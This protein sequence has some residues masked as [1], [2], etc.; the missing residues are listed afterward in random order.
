MYT[1]PSTAAHLPCLPGS[2]HITVWVLTSFVP[3][4]HNQGVCLAPRQGHAL[5]KI[6]LLTTGSFFVFCITDLPSDTAPF[7]GGRSPQQS[8]FWLLPVFCLI[9]LSTSLRGWTGRSRACR[10]AVVHPWPLRPTAV[11]WGKEDVLLCCLCFTPRPHDIPKHS[12]PVIIHSLG[13]DCVEDPVQ[14][15]GYC[16]HGL[17]LL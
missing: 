5:W 16:Y 4:V 2:P 9:L 10:F 15:T 13:Q 17:H 1:P 14:L 3:P 7:F 12:F 8:A 6:F 11:S